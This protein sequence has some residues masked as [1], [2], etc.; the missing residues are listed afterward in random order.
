M[1]LIP[2]LGASFCMWQKCSVCPDLWVCS[3]KCRELGD[4][5]LLSLLWGWEAGQ[6]RMGA[7][8]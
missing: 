3:G 6:L 1:H 7:D 5:M 4:S 2:A 8:R